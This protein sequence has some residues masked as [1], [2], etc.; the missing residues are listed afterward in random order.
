MYA[1]Y[2]TQDCQ[3]DN[4]RGLGFK[5]YQVAQHFTALITFLILL[6]VMSFGHF[7]HAAL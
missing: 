5:P 6:I 1:F 3:L 7:L 4:L 2:V